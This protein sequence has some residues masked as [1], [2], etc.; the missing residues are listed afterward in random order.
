MPSSACNPTISFAFFLILFAALTLY[1][2]Q[3]QLQDLPTLQHVQLQSFTEGNS[4]R[5]KGGNGDDN[6]D[7]FF[8]NF[9]LAGLSCE[10]F[11]G[12]SKSASEEMVYWSDIPEDNRHVSPFYQ[13]NQFLTFEPDHGGWNNIRM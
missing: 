3:L 6:G 1:V 7:E 2:N 8:N 9:L 11:G 4:K 13:P 5:S 12:P 10:R